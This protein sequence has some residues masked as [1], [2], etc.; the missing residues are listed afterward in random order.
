VPVETEHAFG[1]DVSEPMSATIRRS[2]PE[3]THLT[4]AGTPTTGVARAAPLW[5]ALAA[6]TA[7]AYVF[8]PYTIDD[9]YTTFTYAKNLAI[10][11]GP[12]LVA[13][14]RVEATSSFL[15]AVLLTPFELSG[16]GAL[17]GSKILGLAAALIAVTASVKLLKLLRPEATAWEETAAGVMIATS[18]AFVLWSM[19]GM[20]H[21]LAAM[22][23]VVGLYLFCKEWSSGSG[24]LSAVPI[25]LLQ[26]IRP[27]GFIF[28]GFFLVLRMIPPRLVSADRRKYV[29]VWLGVLLLPLLC[30]ELWGFW[31]YGYLLPNTVRAKV[32]SSLL[33][34]VK[35][36]LAYLLQGRG[37]VVTYL[38]VGAL[39]VAVPVLF[40][41]T[42][43]FSRE[44]LQS[45][46]RKHFGYIA[47][48]GIILLQALFTIAVGGDWMPGLRFLSHI[49]PLI[50]VA[51]VY[52]V[53]EL[54][55]L[56]RQVSDVLPGVTRIAA[57]MS[58]AAAAL[59]VGWSLHTSRSMINGF[60]GEL[61]QSED[62]ALGGE[63]NFLNG[64]AHAGDV[65]ACSDIGR[66]SYLFS[67]KVF[68]WWGLANEE[69]AE[70]GQA[71][72]NINPDTVLRHK[73]RFVILY[74]TDPVLSDASVGE[75]MA[76]HSQAFMKSPELRRDYRQVFA[77]QFSTRRYQVILERT[78]G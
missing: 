7:H 66:V 32:G 76:L 42:P 53:S 34:H 15:W 62:R 21:G 50:V 30:Y 78:G 69:I 11:N 14:D 72:G 2:R 16:T 25:F 23:L 1:V 65:V 36:G 27:E 47:T 37:S 6:L 51:S 43:T 5:I 68:D 63:V 74:S 18:S 31:Y 57:A 67:G 33:S 4:T 39:V 40:A 12:V 9:A 38:L 77:V 58:V 22:I 28:I 64:V 3:S 61:Q 20:E 59:Y 44:E 73:P 26:T 54:R 75:G 60:V 46:L 19:Y 8:L 29:A 13:G 56:S 41:R 24:W 35:P 17:V 48:L 71:V 55:A 49:V 45:V 52:G 70:S 10:G